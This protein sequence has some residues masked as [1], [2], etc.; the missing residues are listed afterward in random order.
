[1]LEWANRGIPAGKQDTFE[2]NRNLFYVSC[3]R[4]KHGLALL[5]TQELSATAITQLRAWFGE[6]LVPFELPKA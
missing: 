3:S 1:M 5:F 4:P 2:R 6:V